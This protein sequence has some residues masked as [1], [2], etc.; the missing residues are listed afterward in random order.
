MSNLLATIEAWRAW[1]KRD[2]WRDLFHDP[3]PG[4]PAERRAE[5]LASVGFQ[6]PECMSDSFRVKVD[7]L[8]VSCE[9][10]GEDRD[11]ARDSLAKAEAAYRKAVEKGTVAELRGDAELLAKAIADGRER[12]KKD[13]ERRTVARAWLAEGRDQ[14]DVLAT[15]LRNAH[16]SAVKVDEL[17]MSLRLLA[18]K[19]AIAGETDVGNVRAIDTAVDRAAAV[20]LVIAKVGKD[21]AKPPKRDAT[22]DARAFTLARRWID[23]GR[24]WQLQEIARVLKTKPSSLV[25]KRTD[26]SGK[27]VP[28]CPTFMA[29]WQAEDRLPGRRA[30][31]RGAKRAGD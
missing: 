20:H 5:L 4:A 22:L 14:C 23:E 21:K 6:V 1:L 12:Q 16:R 17:V 10:T 27:K 28:R 30:G 3:F 9:R 18:E 11:R 13:A 31:G 15:A 8:Y 24:N 25:G 7:E 19:A 26:R 2:L 29:L